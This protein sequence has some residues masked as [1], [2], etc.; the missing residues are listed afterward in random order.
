MATNMI[1]PSTYTKVTFSDGSTASVDA[2]GTVSVPSG[3]VGEML[4]AGFLL[5]QSGTATGKQGFYGAT[6]IVQRTGATQAAVVTT[7]ATSTTPY[8]FAS[9]AQADAIVTL[10]NELRAALVA[11]GMIKGSA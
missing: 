9:A 1:A 8:G 4:D 7:A 2:Y 11:L 10:V 5:S 3:F 6:P